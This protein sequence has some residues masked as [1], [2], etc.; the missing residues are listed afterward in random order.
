[1]GHPNGPVTPRRSSVLLASG[2][3][4]LGRMKPLTVAAVSFG[5]VVGGCGD[6]VSAW[7][8]QYNVEVSQEVSCP[9]GLYFPPNDLIRVDVS[10]TSSSG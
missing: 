6:S 4:R 3:G 7:L 1:M 10:I 5:V 8:G 2:S 9:S